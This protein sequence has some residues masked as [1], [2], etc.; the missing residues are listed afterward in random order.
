[1][2]AQWVHVLQAFVLAGASRIP[3]AL[4]HIFVCLAAVIKTLAK[5]FAATLP[6]LL[7]CSR[8]LRYHRAEYVRSLAAH[9]FAFPLRHASDQQLMRGIAAV[10]AGAAPFPAGLQASVANTRHLYH[11]TL[12]HQMLLLP[13]HA[14]WCSLLEQH[15]DRPAE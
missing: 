14:H 1:M 2:L 10:F 5:R 12:Q 9:A 7:Q 11:S 8:R 13:G 4:Q 3:E 6:A 15:L